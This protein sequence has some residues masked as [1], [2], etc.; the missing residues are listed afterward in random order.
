MA[1]TSVRIQSHL[2]EPLEKIAAK[3]HRSKS[4]IINQAIEEFLEHERQEQLRW[5]ETLAALESIRHGQVVSGEAVH[6]W[7]D[8]WGSNDELSVPKTGQ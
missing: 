6:A 2:S 7:L 1:I 8:S 4:S 3:L 5:Q